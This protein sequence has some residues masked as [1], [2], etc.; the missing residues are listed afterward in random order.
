MDELTTQTSRITM[1]SSLSNAQKITLP[2]APSMLNYIDKIYSSLTSMNQPNFLTDVQREPKGQGSTTKEHPAPLATL[3][4][5]YEYLASPEA[6]AMRA[7]TQMDLSAP[8][9]DYFISTSHNTYLTGNQLYSESKASAYTNVLLS[10]CRSVEIDVWDGKAEGESSQ[11]TG[12]SSATSGSNP[13]SDDEKISSCKP[14]RGS[15]REKL[16]KMTENHRHLRALSQEVGKL[17][18]FLGHHKPSTSSGSSGESK[19]SGSAIPVPGKPEPRVLHGHTL[20]RETSFREVCYAIRDSAFVASDLP[21]IV[22]LEVHTCLEQQQTMVEIMEEAWKGMLVEVTPE[23]EAGTVPPPPLADLKRK[24]LIKVKHVESVDEGGDREAKEKAVYTQHMEALKQQKNPS[25][26]IEASKGPETPES[27]A[28]AP[29]KPSKILQALSKL[30]VFTKGFHFSNF[31]QPEA[32]VPSHVFSLSE[33]AVREAHATDGDALFEHNRHFFM[34]VYPNGLRVD[35][36]NMDPTFFWRRGAQM[37]ALNWQNF[38]KAMMLNAGMFAGEQGWVLKPPGYRSSDAQPGIIEPRRLDLT[39]EFLAGQNI[40]LPPGHTNENKFYPFVTCLLHVETPDDSFAAADDDTESEKTGYK[41][42]TKSVTGVNPDFGGQKMEFA[43]VS[44]FLD[45]LTFVRFKIKDNEWMH[46]ALA[47]W[48]CIRLDRLQEGDET[49]PRCRNCI[50]K[51]LVCRYGVQVTF[52]PKNTFTVAEGE[53]CTSTN[54]KSI[55]TGEKVV[56]R[57]ERSRKG[58]WRWVKFVNEDPTVGG[59]DVVD[60]DSLSDYARASGDETVMAPSRPSSEA[61]NGDGLHGSPDMPTSLFGNAAFSDRDKSAVHGLLALGTGDGVNN[62]RGAPDEGCEKTSSELVSS[63]LVPRTP[64][65]LKHAPGVVG[66]SEGLPSSIS[67]NSLTDT[68]K[69]KLLCHY[70]YHVAPWLDVCDLSHPFGI[71]AVQMALSSEPL[72]TALLDLSNACVIQKDMRHRK[73][74]RYSHADLCTNP[75]WSNSS[76]TFTVE[77]AL[78]TVL[79]ETRWLVADI[80]QTWKNVQNFKTRKFESLAHQALD[81]GIASSIYWMFFRLDLSAALANDRPIQIQ[82]PMFPVPSLLILSSI[83]EVRQRTRA[84]AHV[85]LWLCGKA[86]R[87]YH[88]Q[89][90]SD[91]IAAPQQ[92]LDSW[93]DVFDA[94]EQWYHLR[95]HEFQ[96]MVDLGI[97]DQLPRAES[98]FPLLLFANGTGAFS[99]QLYHTAMLLLLQCKPRTALL[100]LQSITL[101]PLWHSQRICGIALNNDRRESWDPCLIASFLVAARRMTHE[102]Q[103]QEILEGFERVRDITGWDLGDYMTQLREDWSFLDGF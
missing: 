45:E 74:P 73:M 70:R 77:N 59:G 88:Q 5:F 6:S 99:N 29:H 50:E 10:G 3:A 78:T 42:C 21:V 16:K 54:T 63:E 79:E 23:L 12:E 30:A 80:A 52:L 87:V 53:L 43:T 14:R 11:E 48:A 69:L 85:L 93:L 19:A 83:E 66:A 20:T 68:A 90:S 96:P 97:D 31:A 84:Y 102:S 32:K 46:N 33:K 39:I 41:H 62:H 91:Q 13:S 27:P 18:G 55:G 34:R 82:L 56:R 98:G 58:R 38:D 35:S 4:A 24:I 9:T 103:Q 36:S 17:E 86:L 37:V 2:F 44:G 100:G 51:N 60:D 47:A 28:A 81:S 61:D 92:Q 71:T 49:K 26:S 25:N 75:L 64:V 15:K 89:A 76:A 22:S 7:A 1:D 95:P 94:I 101:S 8:I 57:Q 67:A 65:V 40:P 72:M